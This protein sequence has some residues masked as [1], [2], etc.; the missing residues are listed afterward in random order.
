MARKQLVVGMDGGATKTAGLLSDLD[1]VVLAEETGGASNPQVVGPEKTADVIVSLVEK[2]C[3]KAN[4]STNEVLAV[5]AGLAGAGREG[6]KVRVKTATLA[7]AK[8]RRVSVGTVTIESDG[9]IALEGAFKGR[10]GIILIAG[11]GSFA[12]AKDHKGGI[13]RA[14]GWGRV[15][16]DEGSGFVIGRDGLN[17]VAKHIDGRGKATLLTKLVDERFGLSNQ[18]KIINGVYRERFDVATV[19]PLVIEAAEAK[20]VECARILNKATFELSE[21]VRTLVNKIEES[22]RSRSKISLAFIGSLISNDNIY[23]KILKQ[24]VTFSLPQVTV[25]APEAP[26]AYGAVLLSIRSAQEQL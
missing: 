19:A 8:R 24:K 7:E 5:V 18:E 17:I 22:S 11:T 23:Q 13:H 21:H 6:D 4:C 20:D 25:I 2:L 15:V 9:R 16:G 26:P 10:L 3:I 1:G 14:G 12:L